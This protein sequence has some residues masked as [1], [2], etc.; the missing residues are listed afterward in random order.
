LM[1]RFSKIGSILYWA[2]KHIESTSHRK[3]RRTAVLPPRKR[4]A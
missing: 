3:S 1:A 4:I 2:R